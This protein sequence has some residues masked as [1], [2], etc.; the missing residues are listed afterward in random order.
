MFVRSI[1]TCRNGNRPFKR[2]DEICSST[3]FRIVRIISLVDQGLIFRNRLNAL[4]DL[5]G[6]C[7]GNGCP[8]ASKNNPS[9]A[10]RFSF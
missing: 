6:E 1:I 4:A 9:I 2:S 3:W 10:C 8:F 7:D 5:I